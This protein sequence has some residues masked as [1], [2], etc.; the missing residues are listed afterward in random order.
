MV[1]P[2]GDNVRRELGGRCDGEGLEDVMGT[3]DVRFDL[4]HVWLDFR[5]GERVL[6]K[7]VRIR[8]QNVVTCCG[9]D[10]TD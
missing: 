5:V 6:D 4:P 9:N 2:F 8:F 7:G 1:V 3:N 10:V